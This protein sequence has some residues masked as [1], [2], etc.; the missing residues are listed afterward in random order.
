M[1][2]AFDKTQGQQTT[3]SKTVPSERPAGLPE[4]F[5]S[6]EDMAK[7]NSELERKQ[8]QVTPPATEVELPATTT[9][10]QQLAESAGLD[11]NALS[12]E[13]AQT[14]ALSE[15]SYAAIAKAGFP[16][17]A[18]DQFIA[19]QEAIAQSNIS[20]MKSEFGGDEGYGLM[21]GWASANLDPAAIQA[22]N[23]TMDS[24]DMD[25]IR[26]AITGLQAKYT[27]ANG[28]EP[29]LLNG[30][31]SDAQEDVFRSTAEMTTAMKD[32]RYAK[33]PAY[34]AEVQSKAARS[35]VF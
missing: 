30:G 28:S 16:K 32:P 13:Y 34:R 4:K 21:V 10:A 2:D 11:F 31:N 12:V 35:N 7:A 25:S 33:D 14:G 9:E 3:E 8:S 23:R 29:K 18:V 20:S 5:G 17:E 26:L 27:A 22:F 24:G 1:I 6:W 19:G 15:A